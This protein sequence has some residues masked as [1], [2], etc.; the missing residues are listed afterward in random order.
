MSLEEMYILLATPF[1]VIG[2]IIGGRSR[3][4]KGMLLGFALGFF[5]L[6]G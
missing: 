2:A 3:G 1:M 5:N 4:W 6:W